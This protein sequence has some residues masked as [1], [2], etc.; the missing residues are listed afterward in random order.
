MGIISG[1]DTLDTM[2]NKEMPNGVKL[3]GCEHCRSDENENEDSIRSECS[4]ITVKN[5]D[6]KH[7][8]VSL[9]L[10]CVQMKGGEIARSFH[11]F[12]SSVNDI[13]LI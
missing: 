9:I 6:A 8:L 13:T 1:I 12:F 11:R 5:V 10:L 7:F 4:V 3:R 2:N